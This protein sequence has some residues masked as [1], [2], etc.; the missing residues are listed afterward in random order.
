MN[1][2]ETILPHHRF[3]SFL[4]THD[5]I[6]N[7]KMLREMIEQSCKAACLEVSSHG[8][9]QRRIDE[10]S[11]DIA[12]FTNLFPDHLDYHVT[13]EEY[14]QAKKGLMM[15]AKRV[16]VNSDSPWAS[17]MKD[18]KQ[19]LSFGLNPGADLLAFDF[20]QQRDEISFSL[21][22]KGQ[23]QQMKSS[24][25]G[26]FNVYNILGAVAVGLEI[27]EPLD[28][29]VALLSSF[30][31]VPGRLQLVETRCCGIKVFVDHAH[32]EEALYVALETLS[33]IK[34]NRLFVVFGCG[35]NRDPQRRAGMDLSSDFIRI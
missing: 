35:G 8:V 7:Q 33:Q 16:I 3:S 25:M 27:G 6:Y 5:V 13:M 23:T 10:I 14:A 31:E 34:Q 19:G 22:F 18:G 17:F 24:L 12:L 28:R 1:S 2:V 9:H 11:F 32:T 15:R 29:I 26:Q 4:T 21:S 20:E 30:K